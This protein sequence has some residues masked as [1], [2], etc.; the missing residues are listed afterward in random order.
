M[1]SDIS[2]GFVGVKRIVAPTVI[3]ST[4]AALKTALITDLAAR[5]KQSVPAGYVMYPNGYAMAYDAPIVSAAKSM[6][7]ATLSL[8][9]TIY[10]VIFKQSDLVT[11]L[12]GSIT[13]QSFGS[14]GY[15]VK[16]LDGL[17]MNIVNAKDFSPAKK[18]ALIAHFSG[19]IALTGSVP[20]DE[21]KKKFAGVSLNDTKDILKP[22]AAVIDSG[23]GELTP[24][25]ARV[26][27]D[28]SR[29]TVIV[30]GQ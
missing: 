1:T 26:P 29:I 22:Y 16:G 27:T 4:T 23:S 11:A 17:S 19:S 20:T 28:L 24:P 15:T 5:I 9:A 12:A 10:G 30:Q 2:G 3:A 18:N 8:H 13:P 6:G 21:L 7:S 25:W 14:F